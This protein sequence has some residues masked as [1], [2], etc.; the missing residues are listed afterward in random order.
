MVPRGIL[1]LACTPTLTT[2]AAAIAVR[3]IMQP[4]SLLFSEDVWLC[5]FT[6][7]DHGAFGRSDN[8]AKKSSV[9]DS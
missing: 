7:G 5:N 3:P 1:G 4:V 2:S 9:W 6:S 8:L